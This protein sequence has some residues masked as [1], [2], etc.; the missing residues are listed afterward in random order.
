MKTPLLGCLA[1]L[2]AACGAAQQ[3]FVPI[4]TVTKTVTVTA[5]TGAPEP[6]DSNRPA[7][8]GS[9]VSVA[10]RVGA[11]GT[12]GST[13]AAS[14]GEIVQ[15]RAT[16]GIG[17]PAA[18]KLVVPRGPQPRLTVTATVDG[19]SA[20]ASVTGA[21]GAPRS[22]ETVHYSCTA[23]PDPT[24]C[25]VRVVATRAGA[26]TLAATAS[27][28]APIVLGATVGRAAAP[29][30]AARRATSGSPRLIVL[31]RAVVAGAPGTP[32]TPPHFASRVTVSPG[33]FLDLV[34]RTAGRGPRGAGALR[35]T[36]TQGPART[37]LA[38]ASADGYATSATR[39]ESTTSAPIALAAP[40]YTCYLP[41]EPTA[42]PAIA[43]GAARGTYTASF[44]DA[45]AL[46]P[47]AL[48][49]RVIA[50]RPQ[51]AH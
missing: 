20:S 31:A 24:F 1:V 38:V 29:P 47:I 15:F 34:A 32:A 27:A 26:Y 37:L 25:P 51:R 44:P 39:I 13:V 6:R 41:P 45:A 14:P 16:P 5:P 50:L 10:V 28:R 3:K 35:L 7:R 46:P 40:R 9:R 21:G 49:A 42:C 43:A 2:L 18:V 23:P 30:V 4:A 17:G 8:T 12:W 36:L 48:L 33:A 22:L 19:D 11:S